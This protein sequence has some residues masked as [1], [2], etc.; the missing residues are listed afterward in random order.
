[1]LVSS[2]YQDPASTNRIMANF[3][4]ANN[5]RHLIIQPADARLNPPESYLFVQDFLI[6]SC[7]VVYALCYLFCMIR[8]WRDKK[9]PGDEYGSI[10]FLYVSGSYSHGF[11]Y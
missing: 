11:A 5:L 8:A 1:M 2:G 7:G 9:V 6:I 3:E 4:L 10:Q